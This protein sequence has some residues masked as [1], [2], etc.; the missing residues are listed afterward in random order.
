MVKGVTEDLMFRI[1]CSNSCREWFITLIY[2]RDTELKTKLNMDTGIK[3]CGH[4]GGG[5]TN[6]TETSKEI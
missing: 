1:Y 4:E 3:E 2:F 5:G 6:S